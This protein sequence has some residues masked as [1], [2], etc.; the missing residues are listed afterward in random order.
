MS[1][2]KRSRFLDLPIELRYEIYRK[3]KNNDPRHHPFEGLAITSAAYGFPSPILR[4]NKQLL[5]E[6]KRVFYGENIWD[7]LIGYNFNYFRPD[8]GLEALRQSP[9]LPHM[10][11][12]RLTYVLDGALLKEYP[13]F[14]LERYCYQIRVNATKIC[15]VLL[16]APAL[17]L[18]ELSWID[19]VEYG[20]WDRKQLLLEPLSL[21]KDVCVTRV[22]D[23][24][25]NSVQRQGLVDY[26]E[27]LL[28]KCNVED[29]NHELLSFSEAPVD[30]RLNYSV[31]CKP[32]SAFE[33]LR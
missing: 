12:F 20:G 29:K 23:V 9:H 13:S 28:G 18:L 22:G 19:T 21:L 1:V 2:S 15:R 31:D 24:V 33:V 4:V 26:V 8:P 11:R 30:L 14:G 7:V 5:T 6:A 16:Q 17:Q 27:T 25:G 10:R 32:P 3:L